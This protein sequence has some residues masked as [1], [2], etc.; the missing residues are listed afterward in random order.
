MT[1]ASMR[2]LASDVIESHE[3]LIV[4]QKGMELVFETYRLSRPF[5][6]D[7]RFGLTAQMRRA[8]VSIPST[9]A[10]GHGRHHRRDYCRFLSMARGSVKELETQLAIAEG[11][12]FAAHAD[13]ERARSLCEE[14][15][16]MLTTLQRKLR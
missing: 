12:R 6:A 13:L 10:E 16:R 11:L 7:E 3:D 1:P 4:W 5:P 8:A 14:L 9:I 2:V 15:S